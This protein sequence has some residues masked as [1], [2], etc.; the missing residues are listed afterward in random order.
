MKRLVSLFTVG[1]VMLMSACGGG[2][3]EEKKQKVENDCITTGTYDC[4][5]YVETTVETFKTPG[6]YNQRSDE[7]KKKYREALK[8][9]EKDVEKSDEEIESF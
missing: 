2:W 3:T 7:A 5:C 4:D 1:T 8:S 6:E 9:C